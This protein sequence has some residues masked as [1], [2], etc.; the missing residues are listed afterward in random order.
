M[1]AA[2][3][4]GSTLY[5]QIFTQISLRRML[6]FVTEA[7]KDSQ[8]RISSHI[9]KQ[10]YIRTELGHD[11]LLIIESISPT[12]FLMHG[13]ANFQATFNKPPKCCRTFSIVKECSFALK[14]TKVTRF[15]VKSVTFEMADKTRNFKLGT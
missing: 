10:E 1:N 2:T 3:N 15:T 14:F 8:I 5:D 12:E 7:F 11:G 4:N 6:G 9:T 13:E